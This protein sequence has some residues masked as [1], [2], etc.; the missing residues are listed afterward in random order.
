MPSPDL[1]SYVDLTLYDAQ[2]IDLLNRAL[3][4]ITAKF[5]GFVTAEGD[6]AST[7]LEAASLIVAELV[8]AINRLPGA[9][10]EVLLQLYGI[11]KGQGAQ[12]TAQ[13]TFTASDTVGHTVP[14]GT[15]VGL[16]LGNSGQVFFTLNAN[17]VIPAGSDQATGEI[18]D[19]AYEALPNGTAAGTA[20]SIVD[21]IFWIQSVALASAPAGGADPETDQ[22]WLARG[23]QQLG[24]L[25]STLVLPSHFTDAALDFTGVYRATTVDNWNPVGNAG[26]TDAN[27][28]TT[29]A[30]PTVTDAA[31]VAG[32][33]GRSVTGA[34]IPAGS[35][36]GVVT[37]GVS[38]GLSSSATANIPVDATATANPVALT[39]GALGAAENGYV[40]VAVL[41][42]SGGLGTQGQPLSG[43]DMASLATQLAAEALANL[44]VSVEP[45]TVTEI[46]VTYTVAPQPGYSSATVEANVLAALQ[47][48]LWTD[49]WQWGGT[50][51][52][53][54]VAAVISQAQGVAYIPEGGLTIAIHGDALAAAD[55][56]LPGA[57]PLAALGTVTPTV[58]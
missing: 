24:R 15:T 37:A 11:S 40:M 47:S 48:Y 42:E 9:M 46:D 4:N 28:G 58:T 43:A 36:V 17:L 54:S 16:N 22:S 34:G 5:P 31:I 30:S 27:C 18:T 7:V 57:A 44:S 12:A 2:P 53:N 8:Y 10:T 32:D 23:S 33:V 6:P 39:L 25:V 3:A 19:L 56:A 49:S 14:A 52:M 21:S 38:F 50:V 35:Y 1:S 29:T 41:G 51:Y 45:P 26:R 55:V 20:L 13:A